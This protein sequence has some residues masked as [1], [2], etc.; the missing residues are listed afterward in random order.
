MSHCYPSRRDLIPRIHPKGSM[1]SDERKGN[2]DVEAEVEHRAD[3]WS[4]EAIGSGRTAAEELRNRCARKWFKKLVA[5]P[6]LD[7]DMLKSVIS[8]NGYSSR[9]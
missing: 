9:V 8:K 3:H 7:K 2:R 1:I 6:S 5:D 4:A